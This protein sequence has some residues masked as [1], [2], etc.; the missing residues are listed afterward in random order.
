MAPFAERRFVPKRTATPNER[1][2]IVRSIKDQLLEEPDILF[3]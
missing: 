3:A 1:E 2:R